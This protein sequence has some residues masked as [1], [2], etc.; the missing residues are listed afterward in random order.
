MRDF[1]SLYLL[2]RLPSAFRRIPREAIVYGVAIALY[3][4]YHPKFHIRFIDRTQQLDYAE[5]FRKRMQLRNPLDDPQTWFEI[6]I[7]DFPTPTD[8]E[9]WVMLDMKDI[10]NHRE[11]L[12]IPLSPEEEGL[13]HL[14]NA[15][16]SYY[17]QFRGAQYTAHLRQVSITNHFV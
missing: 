7:T 12:R 3:N 13:T 4:A 10:E 16:L 14:N 8:H 17:R 6:D 2:I 5:L 15:A 11:E 1:T 9:P